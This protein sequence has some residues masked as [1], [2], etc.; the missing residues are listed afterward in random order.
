MLISILTVFVRC[1]FM[2]DGN[3]S[4]MVNG[5]LTDAFENWGTL[6]LSHKHA[7]RRCLYVEKLLVV[8]IESL[9]LC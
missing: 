3:I 7:R 8:T 2:V 9:L 6:K 4:S 1:D 5:V